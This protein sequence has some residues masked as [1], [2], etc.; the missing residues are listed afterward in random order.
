M[1]CRA[2]ELRCKDVV[3]IKDGV[4]IG[5]V[6]DLEINLNDA[7]VMAIVVYGRWRLFGLLGRAKDIVIGWS[8]IQVIGEDTVLV[9]FE[10]PP[11]R[12]RRKKNNRRRM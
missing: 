8:H 11:D 9:N 3:N 2:N 12:I 5:Y 6:D 1:Y 10:C 7:R 4:R